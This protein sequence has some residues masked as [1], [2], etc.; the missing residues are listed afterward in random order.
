MYIAIAITLQNKYKLM[1]TVDRFILFLLE[2]RELLLNIAN[3]KASAI[4]C[5]LKHLTPTFILNLTLN[6]SK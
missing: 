1:Y 2:A 4:L 3:L 5:L 6:I